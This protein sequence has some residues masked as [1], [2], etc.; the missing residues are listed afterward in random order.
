MDEGISPV[1]AQS[2]AALKAQA[3]PCL[4][5][6]PGG[7]GRSR[8]GGT[9]EMAG[10]WPRYDG[11]PHSCVAQLDLSEVRAAGGPEWLPAEG[12]LLFFYELEHGSWG[13]DVKDA[14]SAVVIH[15][16]GSPIAATEPDDLPDDAKLLAYPIAFAPGASYPSE[17]RVAI[18]WSRLDAASTEAL[19]RALMDLAPAAPAHQI[20]GYPF[21]V[22]SDGMEAECQNLARRLGQGESH[23]AD[24]RLLL[25]L[26]TDEE[27]GVM[28]YDVGSLYFW[29]R[30]Q[31]ARAGDFSKVWTILQSN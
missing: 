16:T 26:D 2:I 7:D 13:L 23:T 5:L 20:G 6:V 21:P 11:R 30:E 18:D 3:R 12:R 10:A 25:Q 15:E 4:R 8:L 28:W 14:G 9:P 22:Q 27:A 31:D 17:E 29:I 24:W 19:E 1:V